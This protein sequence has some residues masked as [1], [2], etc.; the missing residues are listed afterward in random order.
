MGDGEEDEGVAGVEG[1]FEALEVADLDAG[2]E[3]EGG[4]GGFGDG[5]EEGVSEGLPVDLDEGAELLIDV[6]A[7]GDGEGLMVS[8]CGVLGDP[9]HLDG[10]LDHSHVLTGSQCINLRRLGG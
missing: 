7:F 3:D 4:D 6:G 5:V 8:A 9:Q 2:E 1:G 10:D